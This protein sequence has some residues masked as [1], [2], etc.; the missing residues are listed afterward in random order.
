MTVATCRVDPKAWQ[1]STAAGRA[2]FHELSS[3]R[4]TVRRMFLT[5]SAPPYSAVTAAASDALAR[6]QRGHW[7]RMTSPSRAN[8]NG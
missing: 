6:R 2:F 4:S 7:D 8:P 3:L 1:Y 5:M